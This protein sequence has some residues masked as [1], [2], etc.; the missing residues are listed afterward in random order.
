M[1]LAELMIALVV[2][3]VLVA[4]F[5]LGYRR[6]GIGAGL[7]WFLLLVFLATWAG[8]VWL[9]PIGPTVADVPWLSFLFIGLFFSLLIMALLPP[10]P[11]TPAEARAEAGAFVAIN[12]FFWILLVGFVVAIVAAYLI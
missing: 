1:F 8:G 5:G 7:L 12:I 2:A 9:T 4:V 3:V 11:T 10:V 6:M